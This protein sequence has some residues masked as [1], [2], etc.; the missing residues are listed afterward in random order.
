MS[1][2][3][4]NLITTSA[5]A[6]G[7]NHYYYD[8][9]SAS[10][11]MATVTAAG[12]FNNVDDGLGIGADDLITVKASDF[13][14]ILKVTGVSSGSVSTIF[15]SQPNQPIAAGSS[16][17]VTKAEHDGRII[18]LDTAA[19]STI[20][21]PAAEGLGTH[22]TFIVSVTCASNAHVIN[23]TGDDEF[24]GH[25][26]QVQ[27]SND[28]EAQYPSLVADNFDGISMNGTTT[29]G[30]IG[31]WIECVDILTDHWAVKINSNASGTV[32]TPIS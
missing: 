6:Q 23:V 8:A 12:Y 15:L 7:W 32:A 17:S 13:T 27:V 19:G 9:D 18:L 29:G 2:T 30:I 3:K 5:A 4:G 26:M 21:L 24:V 1:Y 31:D 11:A 22:F 28:T 25:A 20:T 14:A 10:D 16:L